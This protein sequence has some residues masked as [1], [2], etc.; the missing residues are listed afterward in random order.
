MGKDYGAFKKQSLTLTRRQEAGGWVLG[1]RVIVQNPCDVPVLTSRWFE[2]MMLLLS[3]EGMSLG[4]KNDEK[5]SSS[6]G[7]VVVMFDP[8]IFFRQEHR[9]HWHTNSRKGREKC[10]YVK[11]ETDPRPTPPPLDS[12]SWRRRPTTRLMLLLLP[13][14]LLFMLLLMLMWRAPFLLFKTWTST[15]L[16]LTLFLLLLRRSVRQQNK[17]TL[18]PK[19]SSFTSSHLTRIWSLL[20]TSWSQTRQKLQ[21]NSRSDSILKTWSH[22]N[23]FRDLMSRSQMQVAWRV[24][25]NRMMRMRV[26]M[27]MVSWHTFFPS[28]GIC[29][30]PPE[31]SGEPCFL[32]RWWTDFVSDFSRHSYFPVFIWW[33]NLKNYLRVKRR[34]NAIP[35]CEIQYSC[36]SR[37]MSWTKCWVQIRGDESDIF[38]FWESGIE[39]HL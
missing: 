5:F 2:E 31:N 35:Y 23:S 13:L 7:E 28:I 32:F 34:C 38:Y 36:P 18:Q 26:V 16:F 24:T 21:V 27:A 10:L 15:T 3:P 12:R 39:Q 6:R 30:V 37:H 9:F 11:P 14:L 20:N 25:W 4:P 17:S 19:I 8:L 33:G 22:Q 29:L 1:L